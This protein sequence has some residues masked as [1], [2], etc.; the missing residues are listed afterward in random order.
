ML[1]LKWEKNADD[2]LI[3]KCTQNV[4]VCSIFSYFYSLLSIYFNKHSYI[5]DED[6]TFTLCEIL[7]R[8]L[9]KSSSKGITEWLYRLQKEFSVM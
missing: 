9:S 7:W 2:I 1:S 3:K 8:I 6:W 5:K 4:N